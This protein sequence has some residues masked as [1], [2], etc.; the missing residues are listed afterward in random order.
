MALNSIG[1]EFR[2]IIGANKTSNSQPGYQ[3]GGQYG[4]QTEYLIVLS[5]LFFF[6]FKFNYFAI[7]D[8][9]CCEFVKQVC[10]FCV[11]SNI[12][13]NMHVIDAVLVSI[14]PLY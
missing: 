7:A 12:T 8:E 6:T 2:R 1:I 5:R 9:A 13:L 11:Q 14:E 4:C 10:C 3:Y